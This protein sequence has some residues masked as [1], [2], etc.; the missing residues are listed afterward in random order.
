METRQVAV[1]KLLLGGTAPIAVQTMWKSPL[2]GFDAALIERLRRLKA[3]GCGI[4]RFACPSLGDA[5][6]LG[7]LAEAV[8]AAD[9]DLPLVA[10]IHFDWRIA[11]RCLDYPIAKIR[12]NPGN[13]GDRWKVE[14]VLAKARDRGVPIRIGVNSGSLPKDLGALEDRAAALVEA[15]ERELS[16][17]GDFGFGE[18]LVSMKAS[19]IETTVRAN[20]AFAARHPIPL[21]LGLTEAGPLI[22]GVVRTAF[23]FERLLGRGIGAT[24]RVSLSD[25]EEYEV[26]AGREILCALGLGGEA[27]TL[28]SCPRCG[29]N[30][31]DTH[32]FTERWRDRLYSIRKKATIAVMGCV[33]NGPGEG[34]HA[35]L[36]ICGSG[37]KVMIFRGGKILRTVPPE[38][39]DREFGEALDGLLKE[40]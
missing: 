35:D 23:A 27:I 22:P 40:R 33:V 4:L 6:V 5:E 13:I 38:N 32:A 18:V 7:R 30:T 3:L 9:I 29:R 31:F 1:G 25:S 14:E 20:E 37:D 11:L 36:G 19:D 8:A 12:I 26:I 28:V 2:P 16:I 17:F 10:D 39:A 34:K 24:I 21:H 15:A